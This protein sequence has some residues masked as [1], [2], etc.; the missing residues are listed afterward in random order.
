MII[1]PRK[2]VFSVGSCTISAGNTVTTVNH[3][4]NIQDL[5][6]YIVPLDDLGG[7]D[8]KISN[9]TSTSFQVVISSSDLDDHT[10]EY[11]VVK[12]NE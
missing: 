10:F 5:Y 6:V 4:L 9:K 3:N 2:E 8:V 11:M 7:R 1:T 12:K